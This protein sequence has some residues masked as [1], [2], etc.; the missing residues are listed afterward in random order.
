VQAP[1]C[2]RCQEFRLTEVIT[3]KGKRE[4]FCAICSHVW[5]YEVEVCV[6]DVVPVPHFHAPT[7]PTCPRCGGKARMTTPR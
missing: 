3:T 5:P 6:C 1:P 2:P 4:G 7:L